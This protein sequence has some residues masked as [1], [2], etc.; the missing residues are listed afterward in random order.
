MQGTHV[1]A[2]VLAVL[3]LSEPRPRDH[4]PGFASITTKDLK[5]HL[6]EV[7][8]P[9]LE[10]RDSPSAGLERAGDYII[11]RLEEAG[12]RGG[13]ANGGFR[14]PYA[15]R[16]SAPVEGA[17]RLSLIGAGDEADQLEFGSAFVPLP[18]CEGEGEG[19][20]VFLGFGITGSGERYD[21]VRGKRLNGDVVVILE[22][23]P[24]HKKLFDGP[25]VSEHAD[26]YTKVMELEKAGAEAVLVIRR[27][28]AEAVKGRD[29]K[30][31]APTRLSY[32]STW[33]SWNPATTKPMN[34]KG[35]QVGIPVAEITFAT[36]ERIFGQDLTKVA[37]KIDKSGKPKKIEAKE[38]RLRLEV[39]LEE[40]NVPIDNVV[41]ILDGTD[42]ALREEYLVLGAHYDHI[43]V[44]TRGRIGTGADD[45]ASGTVGLIELAEALARSPPRRSVVF[46]F[47]SSEEDGLLGS[48][49]FCDR[50]P[51]PLDSIVAMLNMDMIG[52]GE[53]SEVVVLGTKW[54][55]DLDKVLPKAKKLQSTKV[56]R[57]IT[58]RAEHLWQRSDHYSFHEKGIPTLFFFEAVSETDNADYHTFRDTVE[59]LNL[60]KI[61]RTTR[62]VYNAAWLIAN[63]EKRP[64]PP[65]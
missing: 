3:A 34:R 12:L 50:P 33:A 11:A 13:D 28:P 6:A 20:P 42:E 2:I 51:V 53:E 17:C 41:G 55:P 47:F 10:G 63:D 22:G 40:R 45:N 21:D 29:G 43:G 23:E 44:D 52:R 54:N 46:A 35:G 62:L 58:G 32:R 56:K 36:A 9:H 1:L 59:R 64:K 7:A 57:I 16:F 4:K 5:A 65:R 27:G 15:R 25:E 61:A 38:L 14:M 60:E 39:E 30:E 8:S 26:V 19:R 48:A 49:E 31:L 24:R 37:A 18:G